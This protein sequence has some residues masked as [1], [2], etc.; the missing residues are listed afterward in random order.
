MAARVATHMEQGTFIIYILLLMFFVFIAARGEL[1]TWFGLLLW[2]PERQKD[3][4]EVQLPVKTRSCGVFD[5]VGGAC[6]PGG[7]LTGKQIPD[8]GNQ[9]GPL[10]N[11]LFRFFGGGK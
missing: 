4:A 7:F 3:T 10:L 9:L 8:E 5:V 2:T 11:P 6:T 1:P